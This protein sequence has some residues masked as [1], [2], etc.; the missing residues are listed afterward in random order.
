MGGTTSGLWDD[1]QP[2]MPGRDYQRK[3]QPGLLWMHQGGYW[4]SVWEQQGNQEAAP[5]ASRPHTAAVVVAPKREGAQNKPLSE[6]RASTHITTEASSDEGTLDRGKT[7]CR[8][9]QGDGHRSGGSVHGPLS[10]NITRR[11]KENL[12]EPTHAALLVLDLCKS[13]GLW[14]K[15]IVMVAY[16]G[17]HHNVGATKI[18]TGDRVLPEVQP[19]TTLPTPPLGRSLWGGVCEPRTEPGEV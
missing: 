13:V 18:A 12:K 4:A 1:E 11:Q 17:S 19:S 8:G 14:Q 16:H 7:K 9:T 15:A 5:W 2:A 10:L 3:S 6:S